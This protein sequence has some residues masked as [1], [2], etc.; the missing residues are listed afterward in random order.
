MAQPNHSS[1]E[2]P[3]V[4][5]QMESSLVGI[6]RSL[7]CN[8]STSFPAHSFFSPSQVWIQEHS[9]WT[10]CML[11]SILDFSWWTT[12]QHPRELYFHQLFIYTINNGTEESFW[13]QILI[14]SSFLNNV[15]IYSL[16]HQETTFIK[17]VISMITYL[18]WQCTSVQFGK[19][20]ELQ[21]AKHK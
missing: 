6:D 13:T 9:Q 8:S 5:S 16:E 19:T 7:H 14:L 1:S 2:T 20:V 17:P 12:L 4:S 11:T 10:S 3:K 15:D 18:F 21:T